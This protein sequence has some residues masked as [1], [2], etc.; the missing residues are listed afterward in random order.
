MELVGL[1]KISR[2]VREKRRSL[3]LKQ[4]QL[5]SKA[6]ISNSQ[7]NK[8]EN[9]KS[10]P[11]YSLVYKVWRTLRELEE[12]QKQTAEDVMNSPIEWV[13][14][15]TALEKASHTMTEK[16]YSQLPV[17]DGE[18]FVGGVTEADIMT[19]EH[20]DQKVSEV[21]ENSFLEVQPDKSADLVGEMLKESPA[22][23]VKNEKGEYEGIITKSDLIY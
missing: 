22:V 15:D 2:T 19:S 21:M 4:Y 12:E 9:R 11:T 6:G 18:E 14:P 17:K 5:A 7:L 1:D 16:D 8:L 20:P 10:N 13:E 3:G 23:M